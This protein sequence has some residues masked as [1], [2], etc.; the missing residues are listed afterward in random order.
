MKLTG[1]VLAHD[2]ANLLFGFGGLLHFLPR[3]ILLVMV[4]WPRTGSLGAIGI[5]GFLAGALGLA[6]LGAFPYMMNP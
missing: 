1:L 4:R 2:L 6:I 3:V 5:A